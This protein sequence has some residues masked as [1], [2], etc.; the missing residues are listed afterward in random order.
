MVQHPVPET[1]TGLKDLIRIPT[2]FFAGTRDTTAPYTPIEA[3]NELVRL[4]S[5]VTELSIL[6]NDHEGLQTEPFTAELLEWLL[7]KSL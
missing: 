3:H 6:N 5:T 7:G 1:W 2:R 4:G